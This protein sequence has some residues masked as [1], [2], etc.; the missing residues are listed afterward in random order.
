MPLVFLLTFFSL[1]SKSQ[2]PPGAIGVDTSYQKF[3]LKLILRKRE[4][5]M[6]TGSVENVLIG[7]RQVERLI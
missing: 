4:M 2:L 1:T 6:F 5:R 3:S 7:I